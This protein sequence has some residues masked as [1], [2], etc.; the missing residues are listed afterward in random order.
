MARKIETQY[1]ITATLEAATP[2][3]VGGIGDNT[4]VDLALALDGQGRYY[5]PGSSLAGALRSWTSDT[6]G[7][8][9]SDRL[10]GLEKTSTSGTN[11]GNDNSYASFIF[12]ED[13][14]IEQP[15]GK[16]IEEI[17]DGVGIDRQWGTA[18]DKIKFDRAIL[19]SAENKR[20]P[21]ARHRRGQR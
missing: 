12:I 19:Q 2:I 4:L 17:R 13:A 18:A 16:K 9:F 3:H 6:M 5:L 10:F 11:N 1:Q 15:P 20:S 21:L 14:V 7:L 8:D